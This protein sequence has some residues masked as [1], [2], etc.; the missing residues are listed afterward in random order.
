MT[1]KKEMPLT[2][3]SPLY[4][5]IKVGCK[6]YPIWYFCNLGTICGAKRTKICVVGNQVLII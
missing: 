5:Y 6:S 1:F 2:E 3:F 4:T